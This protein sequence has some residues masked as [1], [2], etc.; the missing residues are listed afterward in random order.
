M[1]L[2]EDQIK[3]GFWYWDRNNNWPPESVSFP[4]SYSPSS[5]LNLNITQLNIPAKDQKKLVNDWCLKLPTLTEVK[6]LWFCSKVSQQMFDAACA[7]P[8]LEGLYIKWSS[9]KNVDKIKSLTK[10][11]H[12]RL[13]ASSQLE[14]IEP[15]TEMKSLI[16]LELEKINKIPDFSPIF[17]LTQLNGLGLDGGMWTAQKIDSLKSIEK[18]EGLFYL[19]LTNT[20]I[21]DKSFDPIKLLKNL[22]RFNSSWNY[23][24]SEFAKLKTM[25][26]LKYGNVETTLEEIK[27][28]FVRTLSV[29]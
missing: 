29:M 1:T 25:P 15:L 23:P 6:Y 3:K 8:N 12:L 9:I 18:L 5:L 26:N 22:I 19:T 21:I 2:T 11:K 16:T 10:L 13:G 27:K 20:R 7:I 4:D 14:S 24:K 17:N 28:S